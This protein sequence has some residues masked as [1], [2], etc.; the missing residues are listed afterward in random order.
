MR[1]MHI[2]LKKTP[3]VL[4]AL[5]LA[6]CGGGSDDSSP[7][8]PPPP[9][10]SALSYPVP[11]TFTAGTA[12]DQLTPTV[13]GT[14]ASYIVAPALPTG[15]TFNTGSGVIS[16]T[17]S[18]ITATANY[19]VTASNTSGFTS[20]TLS[21]TVNDVSPVVNYP[22]STFTFSKYTQVSIVPTVDAAGRVV[23]FSVTPALP[24]GLVLSPTTGAITGLATA[25]AASANY[26][27][28]ASNQGGGGA[29]NTLS[30]TVNDATPDIAYARNAFTFAPG[31]AVNLVAGNAGGTT[32]IWSIDRALPAGLNFNTATGIITGVATQ[33]SAPGPY[34]VSAQN[35]GGT[36]TFIL[37][38]AVAASTVDAGLLLDLGHADRVES[39]LHNGS[40]I[41]SIDD[42][43]HAAL[44]N[45]Q[46]AANLASTT[47]TLGGCSSPCETPASLIA[48]AGSTA[49]IKQ[50]NGFEVRS[51]SD[52]TLLSAIGWP[53]LAWPNSTGSW[54]KLAA[55]G[56]YLAAGNGNSLNV[57]S[58]TGALLFTRSGDHSGARVFAAAGQLRL[59]GGPAG[60][61][62]I[63][64]LAI[65]SGIATLS[66]A[67]QGAFHSWFSD[68]ESFFTNVG[69]TVRVYSKIA[70]QRD[71]V[72]LPTTERLA[73]QGNW[74]WTHSSIP[75][76]LRIYAVGAS[77]A[78]AASYSLGSQGNVV[79]STGTIAL[80]DSTDAQFSIIDL[81]GTTP[82]KLDYGSPLAYLTAFGSA[83]ST[84]W[85][86]GNRL[87]VMQSDFSAPSL[88]L[89]YSH[90]LAR[91][92]TGSGQ[93]FAI[94]TAAGSIFYFAADTRQLQGE[95]DFESSDI[96]LS[97]D[98]ALLAA[99]GA[100][101]WTASTDRSLNVYSL[102]AETVIAQWPHAYPTDNLYSF[103]LSL[104]GNVVGQ[105]AGSPSIRSVTLLD[106]TPVWSDN[107]GAIDSAVPIRLSPN[108]TLHALSSADRTFTTSTNIFLN[109][110][111]STVVPGWAVGW[112]D[113]S[114]LLVNQYRDLPGSTPDTFDRCTI[115]N[116]L[117]QT[118]ATPALP[119]MDS[120]QS[121]T[122]S[123]VYSPRH[124]LI[125]DLATGNTLWSST[126]PVHVGWTAGAVAGNFVVFSSGAT[127]RAEPR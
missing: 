27:V 120:V 96:Q 118:I 71:I 23:T 24:A 25:M 52:G 116:T 31:V 62:V 43:A 93:R 59:G 112:L 90:G 57:W 97:S 9:A 18:A 108:G 109:G 70:T 47:S 77:S 117:G 110:T 114:R 3:L 15:L 54:W 41:L 92:I 2:L 20:T 4:C 13:T 98:G 127:V 19:V 84:N 1:D 94:A 64:N 56:S 49:V 61:V 35:S 53:P 121:V 32:L 99:S 26:T 34:V 48:L 11:P 125:L 5:F 45:A 88:S 63:E 76:T 66:P 8:P 16:G 73:G 105:V 101:D 65:P 86:Y 28:R 51:A 111:L 40:R 87:G 107:A 89:R 72:A 103:A 82:A 106:G 55:D 83:S 22:S 38:L 7:P 29:T 81:S 124:N 95:I 78:P 104:S 37:T 33:T 100:F 68:G 30:I 79:P 17:P 50:L 10:P 102:P 14:V 42:T 36:G 21:L 46:T 58:P 75:N 67:F 74:L 113:D 85:A 69:N 60:S 80:L 44:W 6:S 91:K 115:V 119:E 12:I 39:I 126:S 123:S 122:A